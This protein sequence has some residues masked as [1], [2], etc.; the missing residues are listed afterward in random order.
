MVTTAPLC[1]AEEYPK[2]LTMDIGVAP[3]KDTPFNHAKS[4]IKLMEY[5]ASGIP[6]VATKLSSYQRFAENMGMGRL[7][8]N[9]K[10]WVSHLKALMD[11]N[12]RI[13]EGARLRELVRMYDIKHGVTAW[14]DLLDHFKP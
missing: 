4:E 13:E 2:L 8:K 14:N 6:W 3:L 1:E 9:G 5:S 12:T 7:A 10:Q 11:V